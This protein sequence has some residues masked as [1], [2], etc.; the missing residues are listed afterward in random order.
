MNCNETSVKS[1]SAISSAAFPINMTKAKDHNLAYSSL[2][3]TLV[4]CGGSEVTIFW[5]FHLVVTKL[6]WCV[7]LIKKQL[8]K[9]GPRRKEG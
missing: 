4:Y 3:S 1:L 2:T 9:F 7:K 6:N 8:I 5:I